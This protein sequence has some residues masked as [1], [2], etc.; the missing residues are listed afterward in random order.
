MPAIL[1]ENAAQAF[2][3]LVAS[4]AMAPLVGTLVMANLV[5]RDFDNVFQNAGDVIN[6][7]LPP[8]MTT[9]NLAEGGSVQTQSPSLGNVQVTLDNHREATFQIPDITRALASIDLLQ[10]YMEPAI[11]AMATAIEADIL[12][13]YPM[14]TA[15]T[16][17]GG[18]SAFDEARL[19]AADKALFDAKVPAN[20]P[21]YIAVSSSAYSAI[22]QIP[23]FTEN[24]TSGN[25]EAI[26]SGI[27]GKLKNFNII[28]HTDVPLSTNYKNLAFTNPAI[29]LATRRLP[30]PAPGLGVI[31]DFVEYQGYAMNVV[32]S[33]NPNSLATQVTFHSLYGVNALRNQ[34]AV[35]VQSN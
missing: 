22:R 30:L 2:V 16:A 29:S 11:L 26:Q 7:P 24:Q 3:R 18:T 13:V 8:V 1:S 6:V 17:L 14:F 28:R 27:V 32:M 19:D 12:G 21:R 23:R 4:Q 5:T 9:N 34:F 20:L 35:V 10:T 33:Y 15:N 25:G 31:A